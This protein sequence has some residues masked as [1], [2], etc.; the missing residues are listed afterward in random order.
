MQLQSERPP[1]PQ[2][3]SSVLLVLVFRNYSN[4]VFWND[5]RSACC[6]KMIRIPPEHRGT[7]VA[8]LGS[9]IVSI[10][11]SSRALSQWWNCVWF[12]GLSKPFQAWN[13]VNYQHVAPSRGKVGRPRLPFSKQVSSRQKEM[14]VTSGFPGWSICFAALCFQG[15][16]S[17]IDR[18]SRK[19]GRTSCAMRSSWKRVSKAYNQRSLSKS[20]ICTGSYNQIVHWHDMLRSGDVWIF[21]EHFWTHCVDSVWYCPSFGSDVLVGGVHWNCR[22]V[23]IL[24]QLTTATSILQRAIKQHRSDPAIQQILS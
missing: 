7:I 20:Q 9:S 3:P 17:S 16:R 21:L 14:L 4:L 23:S 2:F 1:P 12:P 15:V 19:I 8:F 24:F 10:T 6:S 13:P 22:S 18:V 11:W 5:W